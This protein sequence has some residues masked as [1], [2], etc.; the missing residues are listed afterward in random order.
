MNK[1]E[2]LERID[3]V[4]KHLRKLE[5]KGYK[6]MAELKEIE[7]FPGSLAAQYSMDHFSDAIEWSNKAIGTA[8]KW[9]MKE[10]E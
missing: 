3:E 7:A 6:V 8:R 1:E 2:K 4:E 5:R 10:D 9:A